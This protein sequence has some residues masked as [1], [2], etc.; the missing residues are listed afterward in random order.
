MLSLSMIILRNQSLGA[1][2]QGWIKLNIDATMDE[3]NGVVAVMAR[4]VNEIVSW[5]WSAHFPP[6][7]AETLE[8]LALREAVR[9]A[10]EKGVSPF[11]VETATNPSSNW[12]ASFI[13]ESMPGQL[14]LLHDLII[15][16]I[17]TS[18]NFVAHNVAKWCLKNC[19]FGYVELS[20]LPESLF[21]DVSEWVLA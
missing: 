16:W 1:P 15:N 8:F 3:R 14:A 19:H 13:W 20:L 11:V 2:P 18:V 17:P 4:N 5:I 6:S 7:D 10:V 9:T 21:L 12:R